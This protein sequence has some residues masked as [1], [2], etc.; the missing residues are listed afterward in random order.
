MFRKRLHVIE[1]DISADKLGMSFE[2]YDKLR[3]N[4]NIVIH[5]AASVNF[6]DP[7]RYKFYFIYNL[8][9]AFMFF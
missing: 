1:G 8:N 6:N 3:Q 2:D 9:F 5:S 4:V 7:L